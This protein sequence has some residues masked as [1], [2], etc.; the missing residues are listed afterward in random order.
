MNEP[1]VTFDALALDHA[2]A[3]VTLQQKTIASVKD[4]ELLVRVEYASIN[5]MD[6]GLARRNVFQLPE[7]YVLGFDFSGEVVRAGAAAAGAFAAGDRVFGR[8]ERGGCFARMAAV[9]AENTLR[10]G[11]IPAAEASTYGIAY[12]TAYESLVLTANIQKDAGKWIYVAGA[13]GGLGH[14]AAQL[15]RLHGLRVIG[16]AGKPASARLLRDLK[17]DAVID[18]STQDVVAEVL[19]ITGGKGADLVY[20]STYSQ[21]SYDR[22][23]DCVAA[24]GEYIRLG[25]EVQLERAGVG[26]VTPRVL[27]RG[28]KMIVADLGRYRVDPAYIARLPEVMEGQRRAIAWYEQGKLRPVITSVIPFEAEALQAAFDDFLRGVNNVGKVV[29]ACGAP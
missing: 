20:D 4:D 1:S 9:K 10:R 15:A 28:A 18:Y 13:G 14:F 25:T 22:S 8:A 16:S 24:G 7:P 27:A 6:S 11:A 17:L 3:P 23:A 29:V 5:K 12:L 19:R 21:P 26:D 2:G